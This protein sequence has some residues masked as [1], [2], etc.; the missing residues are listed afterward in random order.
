[1]TYVEGRLLTKLREGKTILDIQKIIPSAKLENT[2]FGISII[3]F[4][5]S[6]VID[7]VEKLEKS[8]IAEYAHPD[9]VYHA[10]LPAP[11]LPNDTYFVQGNQWALRN[12]GQDGGLAGAD[13]SATYA[14]GLLQAN[15]ISIGNS[16]CKVAVIDTGVDY[17]HPDLSDNCK[18]A[19]GVDYYNMDY[20]PM[21]DGDHGTHVAGIIGAKGNNGIGVAGVAWNC[22]IYALKALNSQMQ[23]TDSSILGAIDHCN[24]TDIPIANMSFGSNSYSLSLRNAM[25][26]LANK[27]LFICGSGNDGGDNDSVPFYPASYDCENIISVANT[28]HH[29]ELNTFSN[30]GATSVDVA[31]PG[32]N[33]CNTYPNGDYVWLSGTSMA[34][35]HVTGIAVLLKSAFP[36]LTPAQIKTAILTGVDIIPALSGKVATGGRVNAYKVLSQYLSSNDVTL[37]IK[38]QSAIRDVANDNTPYLRKDGTWLEHEDISG[39]YIPTAQKG[40]G[41]GVATLD[42][43]GYVPATQL[44][45]FVDDIRE[46]VNKAAFPAIGENNLFYFDQA[47][48]KTWRWGGS[49]YVEV[50]GG[51]VALGETHALAYY[52]DFG[53]AAYDHSLTAHAPIDA[54]KNS[55]ITKA[56]IEAKLIGEISTHSH[57]PGTASSH[58]FTHAGGG[59]DAIPNAVLN[60]ASGLLTGVEKAKL[61]QLTLGGEA[62]VNAD[63]TAIEGDAL[64]LNKPTLGTAAALN[65]GTSV[66]NVVQLTT[67]GKLPALDGSLLTN[68]PTNGDITGPA[69]TTENKIPQWDSTTKK[70]KDGLTVGSAAGNVPVLDSEGELQHGI[71]PMASS[72]ALGGVKIGNGIN[73]DLSGVISTDS[74][75]SAISWPAEYTAVPLEFTTV[76]SHS[77]VVPDD[78]SAIT[79]T[80]VGGGGGGGGQGDDGR[81]GSTG[82]NGEIRENVLITDLVGGSTINIVV[83]AGGACGTYRSGD[84]GGTGGISS[85]SGQSA[86]GGAG[87]IYNGQGYGVPATPSPGYTD[88]NYGQAGIGMAGGSGSDGLGGYVSILIDTPRL[89]THA[90]LT[91]LAYAD[92]GHTGFSPADHTHTGLGDVYGPTGAT[93]DAIARYDT[94][95]GKLIQNSLV[96]IDDSGSVNIP[97]EQT[98]KINNVALAYSDV[99]AAPSSHTHSYQAADADLLAIAG[100]TAT[101]GYLR[102]TAADTWTLD[103]PAADIA[104]LT[105]EETIAADDYIAIYDTSAS[106][107]RKMTRA[108]FIAGLSG[109]GGAAYVIARFIEGVVSE[110]TLMYWVAPA[111]CTVSAAVMA[112][113]SAPS[114]TGSY[115]K[116]QVM[117]N[118][119]LETNSIFTSDIAMQITEVT[120]ATNGIYQ[121]AGTLDGTVTLAAG[122]VL[123][124]RVNQ[125]DPGCADLLVQVKVAFT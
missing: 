2:F 78:I 39:E 63:W 1:M 72:I 32:S 66:D 105:A 30:F 48:N 110:T 104:G 34:A 95:T 41:G 51:G 115:C 25:A 93:D 120:S 23:G 94:A 88:A 42:N 35:P 47:T 12:V 109:G 14:W 18:K 67:G 106:A 45:G 118:G 8:G 26:N 37:A 107:N 70:L 117:K 111:A 17:N 4:E 40:V 43:N 81:N 68:L 98:Y 69:V 85:I 96:T 5:D 53:K 123:N 112:L 57:S 84:N 27:T 100:L 125:A 116:V 82:S 65:V 92:S 102:K 46:Y 90:D 64:I 87:G 91:D 50:S 15:G 75:D 22:R 61:D 97:T 83:G 74:A 99:G 59:G 122:D 89:A 101:S 29:D 28:T 16:S 54:Q 114:A 49:V 6:P 55:N 52:G 108:N 38:T 9:H 121:A 86:G 58:G 3:T 79:V 113:F 7:E 13:I 36:A 119:I 31:A 20:D 11:Y 10:T 33:I 56:E 44:P 76:G 24:F 124:F 80:I 19:D 71:I 62:N 77:W 60:G 73:I 21:D 103:T